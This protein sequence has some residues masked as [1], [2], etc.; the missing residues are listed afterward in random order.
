V[1]FRSGLVLHFSATGDQGTSFRRK[2][3]ADP[4]AKAGYA[5]LLLIIPTYGKRRPAAQTLH[6]V[7]NVSDYLLSGLA[8]S[9]EG[10]EGAPCASHPPVCVP[11]LIL[12]FVSRPAVPIGAKLVEYAK[13]TYPGL[14]VC[15]RRC[16]LPSNGP[17]S[18]TAR[19]LQVG[20]TGISFGGAMACGTAALLPREDLAV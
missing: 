13:R 9:V 18:L 15:Y 16:G 14:P 7:D 3:M 11:D 2:L 1:L 10:A 20:I 5:S 19:A 6:Y 4:L 17:P 8:C 12:R